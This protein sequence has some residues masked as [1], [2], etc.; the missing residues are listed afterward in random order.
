[1]DVAVAGAEVGVRVTVEVGGATVGVKVGPMA[2]GVRVDVGSGGAS[3][4]ISKERA[5]DHA[6]FTPPAVRARTR[7]QKRRSLVKVCVVWVWVSPVCAAISG[8]VNELESSNWI[9]YVAA[10]ATALHENGMLWLSGSRA[11]FAGLSSAGAGGGV[12]V[13]GAVPPPVVLIKTFKIALAPP[14]SKATS[15][16]PSPLKS[17]AVMKMPPRLD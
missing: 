4:L 6:L 8:L 12:C 11:L 9:S 7:H 16:L 17:L 1:M 13:G 2:V 15:G 5:E 3:R 10:P 14:T